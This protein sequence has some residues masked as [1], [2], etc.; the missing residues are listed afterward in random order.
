AAP[1]ALIERPSPGAFA[2]AYPRGAAAVGLSGRVVL[3]CQVVPDGRLERCVLAR[4]FPTGAGFGVAALSLAHF[5]RVDPKSEATRRG[6]LDL[7]IGFATQTNEDEQLVTGPWL[8]APSFADTGAAY[9]DI[10]GGVAGQVF[11]HCALERD[12]SVRSCRSRFARPP[13]REFDA[14]ALKLSHEFRM[15]VDPRIMRSGQSMATNVLLSMAA[16]YSDDAKNRRIIDPLWLAVPDAAALARFYPPPAAA[17]GVAS[18]VGATD[19]TVAADGSLQGCHPF[20][21]GEPPGLGFSLAAAK[22]AATLRMSPWTNAGGPVDGA[23]VRLPIRF[24]QV[25]R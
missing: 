25:A 2:A 24:V 14:A 23:R 9:P 3:H 6:D 7:P 12:G 18:G 1:P 10:G 16:P 20:G 11:L 19:C 15:L 21:D 22:V 4:E 5:F 13:D 17:K 8:A